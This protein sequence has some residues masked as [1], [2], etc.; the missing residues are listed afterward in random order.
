MEFSNKRTDYFPPKLQQKNDS[1]QLNIFEEFPQI[2][3]RNRDGYIDMKELKKVTQ[4]LGT[5]LTKEEIEDF[6]AEA[7]KDGNG[8]LDYDEFVKM[9]LQY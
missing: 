6:M 5:M 8:K 1:I 7:D 4:M 2:F 3:D 9:L